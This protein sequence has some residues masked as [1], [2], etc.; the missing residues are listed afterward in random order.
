MPTRISVGVGNHPCFFIFYVAIYII[1]IACE[2]A[3]TKN[4]RGDKLS[5]YHYGSPLQ[6]DVLW[7]VYEYSGFEEENSS[8]LHGGDLWACTY[9]MST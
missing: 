5:Y 1:S 9:D 2:T 7:L 8:F 3:T 6:I 4:C